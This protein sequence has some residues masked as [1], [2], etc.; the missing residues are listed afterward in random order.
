MRCND[1]LY[2]SENVNLDDL[3]DRFNEI[4]SMIGKD[5]EQAYTE[6][7][8]PTHMFL[9][10]NTIHVKPE[11]YFFKVK[12]KKDRKPK[13]TPS[14]Y[15]AFFDESLEKRFGIKYRSNSLFTV[16]NTLSDL[17]N[18]NHPSLRYLVFPK[19]GFKMVT[20]LYVKDLTL[21]LRINEH[22]IVRN[23]IYKQNINSNNSSIDNLVTD[24]QSYLKDFILISQSR[25]Q[26]IEDLNQKD[27]FE[28]VEYKLN[29]KI[30]NYDDEKLTQAQTFINE[31]IKPL[32][33]IILNDLKESLDNLLDTYQEVDTFDDY[34]KNIN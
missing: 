11:K 4:K 10:H 33:G 29:D 27:F 17:N 21:D 22:K 20:S 25:K 13:D 9:I 8:K 1:I 30:K 15:H 19:N 6:L 14:I 12:N 24:M 26:S 28:Y 23:A 32:C 5:Y 18:Y 7:Y 16:V 3:D 31:K 34:E 2:E